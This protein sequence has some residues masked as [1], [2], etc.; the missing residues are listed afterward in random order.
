MPYWC[1]GYEHGFNE[2]QVAIGNEALASKMPESQEPKLIGMEIIRL[3]LERGRTAAEAVEVMTSLITNYGQGK[4]KNSAEIR[5]YDNGYIVADPREAYVIETAG[6]EWAVKMVESALGI[7]NVHSVGTDWDR[8]SPSAER[9]ALES[10]W[11][12]RDRGRFNFKDAYGDFPAMAASRGACRRARSCTVL[13][14]HRGEI[15]VRT[16]MALLRD[17]SDGE[18]P[19]EPFREE[20]PANVSICMHYTEERKANTAASLVADLCA[21]GSRL[22]VYWC[23]FYSPCLGV[24]LPIFIEGRLPSVLSAGGR[25]PSDKSIWWM[26]KN[27]EK[28]ARQDVSG[29]TAKAIRATWRS[30]EDE[31]METAYQAAA[32]AREMIGS[33]REEEASLMLT[34]YMNRNVD[35]TLSMLQGMLIRGPLERSQVPTVITK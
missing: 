13:S 29:E 33:G 25:E 4:F 3:G 10:G 30:F 12:Q 1:W 26:F 24:F 2:H 19:E 20:M 14:K 18:N 6:G 32:T 7:S 28:A 8:L 27:L 11:W 5:T 17:H 23:S 16:I 22:P 9:Y 31:L 35:R 34:E 15:G 21:D